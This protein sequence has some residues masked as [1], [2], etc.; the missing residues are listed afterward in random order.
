[1]STNVYLDGN[2]LPKE[3]AG[4][5]VDDRAV[6]FGEAVFETL[7]TVSSKPFLLKK[8]LV[9]LRNGASAFGL[10]VGESDEDI[11][12]AISK[13]VETAGPGDKRV[14]IT[15][16][17]GGAREIA[18]AEIRKGTLI[19]TTSPLTIDSEPK[20]VV[21]FPG[22]RAPTLALAQ[23]KNANYLASLEARHFAKTMGADDCIFTQNGL[24]LESTAANVFAVNGDT[25][26]TPPVEDGILPGITRETV[27]DLAAS[28]SINI[29][30]KSISKPELISADEVFL[31]NSITSLTRVRKLEQRTFP[32]KPGEI[33][34]KLLTLYEGALASCG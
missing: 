22:P 28:N 23:T 4:I 16:T 19:I 31:T 29:E 33:F 34:K 7:R 21:F 14:R 30:Q 20:S 13:L 17:G 12:R 10:E 24:V 6:L 11:A 9:R 2:I 25:L 18:P 1:M 27:I 32:D 26:I 5:P 15:L 8:H 3:K